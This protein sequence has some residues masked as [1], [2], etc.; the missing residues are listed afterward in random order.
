MNI[1]NR[2][3]YIEEGIEVHNSENKIEINSIKVKLGIFDNNKAEKKDYDVIKE[4]TKE[5]KSIIDHI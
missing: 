2:L 5:L 4:K 3:N 1:T